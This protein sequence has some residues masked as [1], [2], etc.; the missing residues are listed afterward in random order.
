MFVYP[1]VLI[2]CA[3]FGIKKYNNHGYT[4]TWRHKDKWV[5]AIWSFDAITSFDAIRS[6]DNSRWWFKLLSFLPNEMTLNSKYVLRSCRSKSNF[7]VRGSECACM[8]L[9]SECRC[10]WLHAILVLLGLCS[11]THVLRNIF[12]AEFFNCF[13]WNLCLA[14]S[15]GLLTRN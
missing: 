12:S 15:Q 9:R 6:F 10:M 4:A 3:T 13:F 1:H 14:G 5:A 11:A 8:W 2:C 7:S